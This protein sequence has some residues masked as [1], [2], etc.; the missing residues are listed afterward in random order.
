[1]ASELSNAGS[2]S[3]ELACKAHEKWLE[4]AKKT[5]IDLTGFDPEAPLRD[6]ISWAL[7][8]G[9]LIATVYSR[10]SS[11]RQHSTEDQV[12]ECLVWAAG[13]EMYVPP[14]VDPEVAR[15]ILQ[16]FE[17]IA[18]GM[19]IKEGW[20]RW[21][22]ASGPCD[23]RSTLGHMSYNAYRRML[24]NIRYTGRWEFGRSSRGG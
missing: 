19:P 22:A 11:K 12:R 20:R 24:S 13:H 10:F 15:L 9:L 23:P 8:V 1:M 5:D 6:R 7:S 21:V 17:W 3:K 16:H 4:T 18:D 14:E 2:A